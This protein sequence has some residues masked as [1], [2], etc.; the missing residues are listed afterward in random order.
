MRARRVP[1]WFEVALWVGL[2]AGSGVAQEKVGDG[3]PP[4]PAWL[5]PEVGLTGLWEASFDDYGNSR[6]RVVL[7]LV[8]DRKKATLQMAVSR[9]YPVS[10]DRLAL[11]SGYLLESLD[12]LQVFAAF[13]I[14]EG[15]IRARRG[16]GYSGWHR[17]DLRVHGYSRITGEIF[18]RTHRDYPDWPIP[19]NRR[20]E[21]RLRVHMHRLFPEISRVEPEVISLDD[22]RAGN[23]TAQ[24]VVEGRYLPV[25]TLLDESY[26][27]HGVRVEGARLSEIHN[28][29]G[30][31]LGTG[32]KLRLRAE[33]PGPVAIRILGLRFPAVVTIVD[34]KKNLGFVRENGRRVGRVGFGT[35]VF[36][37]M[38]FARDEAPATPRLEAE[39]ML[40]RQRVA[41]H[42]VRAGDR[43]P[44]VYR[45]REALVFAE[46][47]KPAS[48]V[49]GL[50]ALVLAATQGARLRVRYASQDA[51]LLIHDCCLAMREE[52]ERI[53]NRRGDLWLARFAVHDLLEKLSPRRRRWARVA[54]ARPL[55]IDGL[56]AVGDRL[57]NQIRLIRGVPVSDL[58]RGLRGWLHEIEPGGGR[59][60]ELEQEM[61]FLRD[62]LER[63]RKDL[64]SMVPDPGF[65][66]P[67]EVLSRTARALGAAL[68][69]TPIPGDRFPTLPQGPSA[70]QVARV[71]V[72]L[73][74]P[75]DFHHNP[76]AFPDREVREKVS[77]LLVRVA[78]EV[79]GEPDPG[80]R[81]TFPEGSTG[82]VVVHEG[83]ESVD[84]EIVEA[85]RLRAR[86]PYD[87]MLNGLL[88]AIDAAATLREFRDLLE[89]GDPQGLPD[90]LAL[91]G[92]V[93]NL[94]D[95]L[96]RRYGAFLEAIESEDRDLARRHSEVLARWVEC[97]IRE[98]RIDGAAGAFARLQARAGRDL[99]RARK[100]VRAAHES[101]DRWTAE[102]RG[103][104]TRLRDQTEKLGRLLARMQRARER[105]LP[106]EPYM[107]RAVDGIDK[108]MMLFSLGRLF[109][110]AVKWTGRKLFAVGERLLSPDEITK[111]LR[112]GL[113]G[114]AAR[115]VS[116]E[117]VLAAVRRD[118]LTAN[119]M[120]ELVR[121]LSRGEDLR[122]AVRRVLSGRSAGKDRIV[123]ALRRAGMDATDAEK[124]FKRLGENGMTRAQLEKFAA[125][126]RK[127]K[128]NPTAATEEALGHLRG[129][130]EELQERHGLDLAV[131][132]VGSGTDVDKLWMGEIGSVADM[133]NWKLLH[134]DWD[135]A[136]FFAPRT[137]RRQVS[138]L[139][140]RLAESHPDELAEIE[141]GL[142][143][144]MKLDELNARLAA[145]E[146][147]SP[148]RA[149]DLRRQKELIEREIAQRYLE[150]EFSRIFT[151]RAGYPPSAPD[152]NLF[153]DSPLTRLA[154][155][156]LVDKAL[157][158][159]VSL[160]R[161]V[162]V[163]PD[164][165]FFTPGGKKYIELMRAGDRP[166]KRTAQGWR[167]VDDAERAALLRG[168]AMDP[169]DAADL[170]TEMAGFF[171][172]NL[173]AK[174]HVPPDLLERAR[175]AVRAGEKLGVQD[176]ETLKK[177]AHK[178]AKYY[179]RAALGRLA[180]DPQVGRR[181]PELFAKL[182]G[183]PEAK[184]L[185]IARSE[186]LLSA[187]ELGRLRDALAIKKQGL[188]LQDGVALLAGEGRAIGSPAE[189]LAHW[190]DD[191]KQW[192]RVT[193]EQARRHAAAR[194]RELAGTKG[195]RA[196]A[197][198]EA[199]AKERDL[200]RISRDLTLARLS[201]E[202]LRRY[203]GM[204]EAKARQIGAL[205]RSPA[206]APLVRADAR[207]LARA[208][209]RARTGA[210]PGHLARLLRG[211][212][213]GRKENSAEGWLSAIDMPIEWTEHLLRLRAQG[214]LGWAKLVTN[215]S[216]NVIFSPVETL[217]RVV[218]MVYRYT[219]I[220]RD[221]HEQLA[222]QLGIL[223]NAIE[224]R[225]RDRLAPAVSRSV[226]TT[227]WF[228]GFSAVDLDVL[229][230]DVRAF[231]QRLAEA[232]RL[233]GP[234]TEQVVEDVARRYRKWLEEQ[235]AP[236]LAGVR[237]AVAATEGR[238]ARGIEV[239]R[240]MRQ[241]I[242]TERGGARPLFEHWA[243]VVASVR[244]YVID[245]TTYFQGEFL[246]SQKITIP[247]GLLALLCDSLLEELETLAAAAH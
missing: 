187:A 101:M 246:T 159:K 135:G 98:G 141:R 186:G 11:F 195:P 43:G 194:A 192:L 230:H 125:L 21:F 29:S 236:D 63:A 223:L 5:D 154:D 83:V 232:R 227:F 181:L 90:H 7:E 54:A 110:G 156:G 48:G 120:D 8:H 225:L 47:G 177:A 106:Y 12:V 123:A 235:F 140:E 201:P 139:L 143:H 94:L 97:M 61:A 44:N 228:E 85:A 124:V 161:Y 39:A 45:S 146:K 231:E 203:L 229:E 127:A 183:A 211:L 119:E 198:K 89:A 199:L 22:L 13:P 202:D 142:G 133:K 113:R 153:S 218:L 162:E 160:L 112:K 130:I 150:R 129:A 184:I 217:S 51:E 107:I 35:P 71:T 111:A 240:A 169:A 128:K 239:V 197:L 151:E 237:A 62:A 3:L 134:N 208:L 17:F 234:R 80:P 238:Q 96:E 220:D 75:P 188:R 6:R 210:R 1:G 86:P 56:R 131:L 103:H 19:K 88:L 170:V 52:L 214:A 121:A 91:A 196:R 46:R 76:C 189:L 99:A 26:P 2:C 18:V 247:L 241:T 41:L 95:E 31:P 167:Y 145:L 147:A 10:A 244:R 38:R 16:G 148:E 173:R 224:I 200:H 57:Q 138:R 172:Q 40:D 185:E 69:L 149:A 126:V 23:G 132:S 155:P 166:V 136:F 84:Q 115:R 193:E 70:A 215:V 190:Q 216:F 233:A 152:F 144:H 205:A 219:M 158:G 78:R 102:M 53:E 182:P 73:T 33:R 209:L 100:A 212:E 168:G 207:S 55:P 137:A 67:G 74:D 92:E 24:V 104:L 79:L 72:D 27:L 4:P 171:F 36:V 175:R 49:E 180:A 58:L 122:S 116:P 206:L 164:G 37:E 109:G 245:Q 105:D 108:A 60:K 65:A 174:Y 93:S 42:L 20:R 176:L 28:L 15:S 191:L 163:D 34:P 221:L 14:R 117:E 25:P 204:P 157:R 222:G 178:T 30:R 66:R 77:A 243:H 179:L 81:L 9:R 68:E 242:P 87:A 118:G 226:G 114:D 64:D 59:R 32:L 213:V 50:D 82:I 165:V